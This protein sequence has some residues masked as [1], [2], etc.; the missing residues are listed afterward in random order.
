MSLIANASPRVTQSLDN[1][2]GQLLALCLTSSAHYASSLV[3]LFITEVDLLMTQ[4]LVRT[5]TRRYIYLEVKFY[6]RV[7]VVCVTF[8]F[9]STLKYSYT[10]RQ[11]PLV[12]CR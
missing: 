7:V 3:L 9:K 10:H 5:L 1:V 6:L 4:V 2:I 8:Y 11:Y 12:A